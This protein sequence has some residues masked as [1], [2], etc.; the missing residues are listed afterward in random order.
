V[1]NFKVKGLGISQTT[2]GFNVTYYNPNNFGV[3]VKETQA[4]VYI[5]SIYLGK[6]IQDSTIGVNKKSEFSIPLSGAVS[7]QTALQ[8]NLRE[9][10]DK[11]ILLRADGTVRVGKAGIFVTR[12]VNY[13]GKHRLD[14]IKIRL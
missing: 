3:T 14:E 8:L 1:G 7:M 5:D 10:A 2:I 4:D 6:F 11:E 12:K 9:M 13:Q